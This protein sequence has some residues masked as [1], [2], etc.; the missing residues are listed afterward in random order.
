[1]DS[2][3][4]SCRQV[5]S[6]YGCWRPPAPCTVQGLFG[7]PSGRNKEPAAIQPGH[8]LN[9]GNDADFIQRGQAEVPH[10]VAR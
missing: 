5:L 10:G 9:A 8:L 4:E 1:M 3:G 7:P 2:R 6:G